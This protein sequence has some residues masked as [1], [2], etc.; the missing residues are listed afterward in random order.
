MAVDDEVEILANE[1]DDDSGVQSDEEHRPL[2]DQD[3]KN[4][5]KGLIARLR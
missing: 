4:K 1:D 3:H 2:L 5:R